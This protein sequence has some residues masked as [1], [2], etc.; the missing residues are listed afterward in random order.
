MQRVVALIAIFAF[1]PAHAWWCTGHMTI[2]TIA[3]NNMK[4]EAINQVETIIGQLSNMGPFP[5]IPTFV[6]AACW[7]DDLKRNTGEMRNWHFLNMPYDPSNYPIVLDPQQENVA[8][9][10]T[11]FDKSAKYTQKEYNAW[12]LSFSVGNLI[13]FYGDISQPLHVT[14]LFSAQFPTGDKGGNLFQIVNQNGTTQVLHA[15]WDAICNQY[16]TDPTRPLTDSG[17]QV[18]DDLAQTY[19]ET[20]NIS[21]ADAKCWNS[22]IMAQESYAMAIK[23]AYKGITPG[24]SVTQ[25]YYEAC[26]NIAGY[27]ITLAGMRL[28][29]DLN[30]L[31]GR[32]STPS[33]SDVNKRIN[34]LHRDYSAHSARARQAHNAKVQAHKRL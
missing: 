14:E 13:H 24:G 29:N 4:S 17:R 27:Q 33:A 26:A 11:E 25:Q 15:Y 1:V 7:A 19:Q 16:V 30:Y 2:A 20:Y 32:G 23:Y 31:F 34:E 12:Q 28:A 10:I 6:E 22:T 9:E 8:E 5:K 21:E 18:I 3:K